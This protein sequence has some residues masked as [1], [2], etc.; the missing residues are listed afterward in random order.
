[1]EGCPVQRNQLD[2]ET[3]VSLNGSQRNILHIVFATQSHNPHKANTVRFRSRARICQ[4]K[5]SGLIR[6]RD[7]LVETHSE[8]VSGKNW[9]HY[10]LIH[11]NKMD[12][13]CRNECVHFHTLNKHKHHRNHGHI[14]ESLVVPSLELSKFQNKGGMW[15]SDLSNGWKTSRKRGRRKGKERWGT[16]QWLSQSD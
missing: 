13:K 3:L 16:I 2:V 5:R 14:E 6:L 10:S 9:E 7:C 8:F 12:K 4:Q 11:L 15:R 1:M